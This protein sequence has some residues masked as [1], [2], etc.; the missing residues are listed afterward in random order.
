VAQRKTSSGVAVSSIQNDPQVEKLAASAGNSTSGRSSLDEYKRTWGALFAVYW[1]CRLELPEKVAGT[2][3]LGGQLGFCFG[4]KNEL[5]WQMVEDPVHEITDTTHRL[6]RKQRA[7]RRTANALASS[8]CAT[9]VLGGDMAGL[10]GSRHSPDGSRH[11][12]DV[13]NTSAIALAA[14]DDDDSFK[15][16]VA[17]S[18]DSFKQ[19]D[20]KKRASTGRGGSMR[21]SHESDA[22]ILAA[23]EQLQAKL[24]D[25]EKRY[26]FLQA[27]DWMHVHNLMIDAGMLKVV[28]GGDLAGAAV[29]VP[30]MMSMLALTAVHDIMKNGV[31]LPTLL[32]SHSP[33]CG[34][35]AGEVIQDH[36]LALG[37]VLTHDVGALPCIAAL[38]AEQQQ[39]VRFTQAKMGFNHGWLVQA[40]APPGPLFNVQGARRVRR[41]VQL[42]HCILLCSLAHGPRR[43]CT[44]APTRL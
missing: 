29:N 27:Q 30:R 41:R 22:E 31:L 35:A 36:D 39:P 18:D 2:E 16:G 14:S 5:T 42:R 13:I 38:P 3:G 15:K 43:R 11:G 7:S 32:K 26:A 10:D 28:T 21:E 23:V 37:Y 24:T 25:L 4:V 9:S 44:D 19:T 33:F 8:P 40:E 12:L 34:F 20:E 1:L 6:A 17:S